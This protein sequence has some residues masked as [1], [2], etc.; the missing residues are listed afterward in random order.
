MQKAIITDQVHEDL[1][2][3]CQII[4]DYGYKNIE[5]HNVFG[6]TIEA[7]ND[8]EIQQIK[9]IVE[10]YQLQVCNIA[11]TVFFLCPL[12]PHYKVS[13]FNPA[14]YT[15]E[16]DVETHLQYL[17]RACKV[18][19]ELQCPTVR[20]FPF[21]FPDNEDVVVVGTDADMKEISK[22]LRKAADIAQS[23]DR[24]LVLE[25][26]PYS[27]LPKGEMTFKVVQQVNH[28]HLQLLWDPANSY[29]AEKHKVPQAYLQC[30]LHQEYDLIQQAIGH[31]HIKNYHYDPSYQKPFLHTNVVA[32]DIDYME[33]FTL[34]KPSYQGVLSLEPEVDHKQTIV[35]M[36]QLTKI[37]AQI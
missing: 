11:S 27:H 29:R 4:R 37:L 35:S 9:K 24:T 31:V 30:D 6:K 22:H 12:Y 7:C 26:C 32:G 1:E 2:K 8:E 21:R 33:L 36:E 13:L 10:R 14:F 28:K 3:A 5:L 17:H 25:N 19:Q 20:I 15:I 18:A 16:G 23:Y 34:M